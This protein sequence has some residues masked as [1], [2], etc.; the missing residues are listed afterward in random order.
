VLLISPAAVAQ[1][2]PISQAYTEDVLRARLVAV[3][4]NSESEPMEDLQANERARLDV[5]TALTKWGKYQVTRDT[6]V[7]D[8]IIVVR[9]ARRTF[10]DPKPF[11]RGEWWCLQ[12]RRDEFSAGQPGRK[13]VWAKLAP[14]SMPEREVRKIAAELLRP[15][16]QALESIGFGSA[17]T[18]SKHVN[19]TYIPVTMPL[20]ANSTQGPLS[21]SHYQ[22]PFPGVRQAVPAGSDNA[23]ISA[24][25]LCP[26]DLQALA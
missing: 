19:E 4:A 22:L 15:I 9:M 13:K 6:S 11:R 21:R 5:T 1:K 18:F 14:S 2:T 23:Y 12:Y 20:M 7:A 8:L 3:V 25:L 10:Q 17:T 26:G 16:N 24:L